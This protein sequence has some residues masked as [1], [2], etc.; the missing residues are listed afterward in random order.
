[1]NDI[2]TRKSLKIE[3]GEGGG[4]NSNLITLGANI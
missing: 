2:T 3:V 4:A 1:M